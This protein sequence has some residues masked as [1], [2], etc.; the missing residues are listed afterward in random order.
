MRL[1]LL[2]GLVL[3][4]SPVAAAGI[5]L[6]KA[7]YGGPGCPQGTAAVVLASDGSSLSLLFD[8]YEVSAG[9]STGKGFDR[10]SCNLAI[11][12]HVPSGRSVAVVGIDYRGFNQLSAG[13]TSV[14]SVEY[15]LA[16]APGP[17]FTRNF[18]G[19]TAKDFLV[20]NKLTTKSTVWSG[21]GADVIF[22]TNSS[23]RVKSDNGKQA[24]ATV[25]TQDIRAAIVYR[26]QWRSC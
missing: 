14:F 18:K 25:D 4:A 22:R 5:S 24:L 15:F 17:K 7:N 6:G 20:S 16:S 13:S 10:K 2:I 26:L 19:P 1:I 9:G 3:V 23:I 12:V 21:C 11:P 8:Q